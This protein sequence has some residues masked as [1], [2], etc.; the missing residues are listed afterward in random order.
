MLIE[1]SGEKNKDLI[2][3]E[4][5]MTEQKT[6]VEFNENDSQGYGLDMNNPTKKNGNRFGS[7]NVGIDLLR[8]IT[9]AFVCMQ[10]IVDQGGVLSHTS[11][12]SVQYEASTLVAALGM[13]SINCFA[14]ISGYVNSEKKIR[15]KSIVLLWMRVVFYTL[16]ITLIFGIFRPDTITLKRIVGAL[17]PV[18][19]TEYWYF[20]AYFV[21]FFI[22][23]LLNH[24]LA[25]LEQKTIKK[26]LICLFVLF[27]IIPT[28]SFRDPF[29]LGRGNSWMWLAY[30]YLCGGYIK[31]YKPLDNFKTKSL[32]GIFIAMILMSWG[33]RVAIEFVS[34]AV[35]GAIKY[36]LF[37]ISYNSPTYVVACV[38]LLE[39][40]S[41]IQ[42]DKGTSIIRRL[43]EWSFSVYIISTNPLVFSNIFKDLFAP[44]SQLPGFLLFFCL[45]FA[46]FVLCLVCCIID[47]PRSYIFDA[48]KLK[49]K[50]A[51]MI[52]IAENKLVK[53]TV[54]RF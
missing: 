10:H 37:L 35:F 27:S 32:T 15:C 40:F 3:K 12:F 48:C 23:P 9:M 54:S 22:M 43:S 2:T 30:L 42:I 17:L 31:K 26:I 20:T 44:L 41:R 45:I 50:V 8:I 25:T 5:A 16:L 53:L 24:I 52:N 11:V 34:N 29:T 7:R 14:L 51:V 36:E 33:S 38:V 1:W 46:S 19:F 6:Y 39:I 49:E 47:I 4:V 21:L 13:C 28:I 18:T